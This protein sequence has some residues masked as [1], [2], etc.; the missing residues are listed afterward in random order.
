MHGGAHAVGVKVMEPGAGR[1]RWTAGR[2]IRERQV[3]GQRQLV[4]D[5]E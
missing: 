5:V 2:D 4:G 1:Y 3:H